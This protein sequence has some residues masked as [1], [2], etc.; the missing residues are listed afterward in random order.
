MTDPTTEALDA[1]REALSH[2]V[3]SDWGPS[4][5]PSKADAAFDTIAARIKEAEGALRVIGDNAGA[6]HGGEAAKA[7]ALTVIAGWARDPSSIP[8]ALASSPDEGV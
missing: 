2:Y 1:I 7:R 4:P 5:S 8:V 6:W 3:G